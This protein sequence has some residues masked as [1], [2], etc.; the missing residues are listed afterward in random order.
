MER[1]NRIDSGVGRR[2]ERDG[3]SGGYGISGD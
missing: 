1:R 3:G 2:S